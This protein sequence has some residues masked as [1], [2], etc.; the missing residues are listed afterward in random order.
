MK[1]KNYCYMRGLDHQMTMKGLTAVEVA[2]AM[3][4]SLP[5]INQSSK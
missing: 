1:T 3:G 4:K 2:I 5:R